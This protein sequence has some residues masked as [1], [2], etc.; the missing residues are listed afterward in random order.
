MTLASSVSR[1]ILFHTH[2][3]V[4]GAEKAPV[5]VNHVTRAENLVPRCPK[6]TSLDNGETE[7]RRN[8]DYLESHG[9]GIV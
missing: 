2:H 6:C 1:K 9:M 7:A 5:L 3:W 4:T 8:W